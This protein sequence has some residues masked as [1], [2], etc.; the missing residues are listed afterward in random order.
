MERQRPTE[1]NKKIKQ[2][3]S[4]RDNLKGVGR[5]KTV[6]SKKL[7]DRNVEITTSRNYWKKQC[8]DLHKA[9]QVEQKEF[10][11]KLNASKIE[12]ELEHG[13]ANLE[14]ERAEKLEAEI[15]KIRKKKPGS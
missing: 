3:L 15:E 8:K 2:L 4:S 13:R 1:L 14:R 5:Q 11:E 6:C 7:R 9:H 10:S 12:L